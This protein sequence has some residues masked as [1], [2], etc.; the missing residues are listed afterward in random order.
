MK[1]VLY[2]HG[3][4]PGFDYYSLSFR[5]TH[6]VFLYT[7]ANNCSRQIILKPVHEILVLVPYIGLDA[8]KPVFEVS[9]KVRFKPVSSAT[10]TS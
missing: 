4:I 9:D 6:I 5:D 7:Q 10:E 8:R 1:K 2:P 3:L